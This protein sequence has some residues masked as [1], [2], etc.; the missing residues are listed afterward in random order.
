MNLRRRADEARVAVMLLTRLPV[1]RTGEPNPALNDTRWAFVLAGLPV[2]LIGW[3]VFALGGWIGLP[4]L[5]A[6]FAAIAAMVLVTG[7]LHHDG[8]ADFADGIW[9]GSTD[10]RRLEIMRDSR[11]G[12]Y[13]VLGLI[14]A[15]GLQASALT[16]LGPDKMLTSFLFIAVASRLSMLS[17]LLVLPAARP[18]GLGQ[19][20]AGRGW[21]Q[22]VPGLLLA[23]VLCLFN[24]ALLATLPPMAALT[25][26]VAHVS[27]KKPWRTDRRRPRS[28]AGGCRGGRLDD[29]GGSLMTSNS[30]RF[31]S[32]VYTRSHSLTSLCYYRKGV[33][34]LSVD[35]AA[36]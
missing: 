15:L 24:P 2:G 29:P 3:A 32:T 23:L 31:E 16:G 1:G 5:T 20:A 9:G 26:G 27:Q 22:I 11:I 25:A 28:D 10:Q 8:L 33:A 13:G 6:S 34:I 19:S 7:G 30:K 18:D 12:S 35:L 21:Q 17:V 4:P 36:D 14:L